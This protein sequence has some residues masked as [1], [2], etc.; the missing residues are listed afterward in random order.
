M[1]K[2]KKD[3]D[4]SVE[5]SS[6]HAQSLPVA[7]EAVCGKI[8]LGRY[9]QLRALARNYLAD[10]LSYLFAAS[11]PQKGILLRLRVNG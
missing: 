4:F 11:R 6:L 10:T 2:L 7:N 8:K 1:K 9:S 3:S 5:C